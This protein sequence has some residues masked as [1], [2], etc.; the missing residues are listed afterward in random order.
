MGT[1]ILK[2]VDVALCCM[3]CINLKIKTIELLGSHYSYN[4]SFK[5]EENFK[6][7]IDK[8]ERCSK[9]LA[10]RNFNFAR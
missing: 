6:S 4:K 1:G 5:I 10:V 8:I 2:G 7:H 9:A 3:E